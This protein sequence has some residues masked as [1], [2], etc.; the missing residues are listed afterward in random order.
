MKKFACVFLVLISLF[1]QSLANENI[2]KTIMSEWKNF[3]TKVD[4]IEPQG[5]IGGYMLYREYGKVTLLWRTSSDSADN[6][7]IRF[8][9]P[10]PN[11]LDFAV[12]YHKSDVIVPGKVVLR[13]FIGTEPTGWINHTVEL[14][15]GKYLG[16]QGVSSPLSTEQQQ[17]L[18]EWRIQ[19]FE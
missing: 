18:K 13:R 4:T 7:V 8:F 2:S 11:G 16:K 3:R 14:G 1:S 19:N 17:L 9:L 6:E 5:D 10:N 12:T 15:T